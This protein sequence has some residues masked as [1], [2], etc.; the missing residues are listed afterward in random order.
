MVPK[1][2]IEIV[3]TKSQSKAAKATGTARTQAR[4][5]RRKMANLA[6]RPQGSA[7]ANPTVK[8]KRPHA[9][10]LGAR[11]S[12]KLETE[13]ARRY[14]D[15]LIVPESGSAQFPD[16][17]DFPTVPLA[18]HYYIAPSAIQDSVSNK[19]FTVFALYPNL[20]IADKRAASIA[21]GI[22]TW[23]NGNSHPRYSSYLANFSEYRTISLCARIINSTNLNNKVGFCYQDLGTNH[24]PN[25]SSN[26]SQDLPQTVGEIT[27]SPSVKVGSFSQEYLEDVPRAGWLPAKLNSFEFAELDSANAINTPMYPYI[28]ILIDHQTT[29]QADVQSILVEVFY[30]LEA[31]PLYQTAMLFDPT[32]CVG[33]PDK[34]ATGLLENRDKLFQG[35]NASVKDFQKTVGTI[36]EFA[37]N[38]G[39]LLNAFSG[40]GVGF[41][42]AKPG[43]NLNRILLSLRES[44][45]DDILK[46][47]SD[48]KEVDTLLSCLATIKKVVS[49]PGFPRLLKSSPSY[50]KSGPWKQELVD[51]E[52]A[53]A[54]S[55]PDY[56][57]I[58]NAPST[59]KS[60]KPLSTR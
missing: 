25:V 53:D 47:H 2:V 35:V 28:V 14:F 39:Q 4:K 13:E 52:V 12:A 40:A 58:S 8:S 38:T 60:Q 45:P 20:V 21:N 7:M 29:T 9:A 50:I 31:I 10:L 22:I 36:Q 18:S 56:E 54:F 57:V 23:D 55:D 15:S 11:A 59:L 30:N 37:R 1:Q 42:T 49:S 44:I 16:L 27:S 19:W 5:E 24:T 34:I 17:N 3:E 6:A 32:I 41:R 46:Y 51:V 48:S 33:S 43:A 26:T